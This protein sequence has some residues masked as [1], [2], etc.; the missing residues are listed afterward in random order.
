MSRNP[1]NEHVNERGAGPLSATEAQTIT[2]GGTTSQGIGSSALA[3][4]SGKSEPVPPSG[5]HYDPASRIAELELRLAERME[6]NAVLDNEVR[7]LLKQQTVSQEYLAQIQSEAQRIPA[8]EQTLSDVRLHLEQVQ[9]ELDA[10]RN[11]A[12]CV[13]I[14]RAVVSARRYPVAYRV[15]RSVTYRLVRVLRN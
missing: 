11:R 4:P 3:N 9:M 2:F 15:G 6:E 7:Y 5:D 14:D 1:R 10:F 13:L 12:S 8:L